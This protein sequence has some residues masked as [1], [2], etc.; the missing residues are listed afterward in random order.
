MNT[1]SKQAGKFKHIAIGLG[2]ALSAATAAN[3]VTAQNTFQVTATITSSCTVSGS[4]LNFGSAIDPLT[5]GVPLDASST[6]TVTCSNTTPYAVSLNAGT[7]AGGASNFTSRTMKS[8]ANTLGYQ[9]YLD[10]G[11]TT[12]FGDGTAS[13]STKSGTGSGSAQ[14]ISVYGRVPTLAGVVPGSYTD[15]VTVTITY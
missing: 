1:I 9:L 12:V 14:S 15:T 2:L 7:N 3:A 8:G 13:S 6:L 10:S 4:A 11:R 5:V